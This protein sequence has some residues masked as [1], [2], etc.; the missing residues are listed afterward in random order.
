MSTSRMDRYVPLVMEFSARIVLFHSAVADKLGLHTTDL[1]CLRLLGE[2]TLSAGE[3]AERTGL[4]GAAVTALIDRLENAGY[5][6]RN[7][8]SEDRRKVTVRAIPRSI[9][10]LNELYQNQYKRMSKL[11][12]A[13]SA[14]EFE[15]IMDFLK[16]TT[17]ILEVGAKELRA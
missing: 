10:K 14:A 16:K 1:K 8:E 12:D 11:I 13:Y 2:E 9:R 5:V 15:S 3:L 7:R 6:T 17:E 4:T